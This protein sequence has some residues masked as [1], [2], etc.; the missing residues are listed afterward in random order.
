[1]LVAVACLGILTAQEKK[2]RVNLGGNTITVSPAG[3]NVSFLVLM[4]SADPEMKITKVSSDIEFSSRHVSFLKG[5]ARIEGDKCETIVE[6]HPEVADQSR[7]LVT[8]SAAPGRWLSSGVIAELEFQLSASIPDG[9]LEFPVSSGV[10][11][12]GSSSR[13]EDVAG[14]PGLIAVSSTGPVIA[15]C[16]FYMH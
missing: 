7:L 5:S 9:L 8:V 4:L 15:A 11:L 2:V 6:P 1:M 12:E 16:F 10:S 3:K 14:D 13:L